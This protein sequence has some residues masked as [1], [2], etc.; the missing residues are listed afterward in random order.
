MA[1][2]RLA[3]EPLRHYHE[4]KPVVGNL[5]IIFSTRKQI[6]LFAQHATFNLKFR[7]ITRINFLLYD[8][9]LT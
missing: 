4:L 1:H 6:I 3:D 2:P 9:S 7:L 8:P 5:E